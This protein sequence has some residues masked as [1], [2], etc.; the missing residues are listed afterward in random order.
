MDTYYV[1][2]LNDLFV[3]KSLIKSLDHKVV[4]E[5][6]E[7]TT[8]KKAAYKFPNDQVAIEVANKI[9]GRVVLVTETLKVTE[10]YLN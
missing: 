5:R 8:R 7:L 2:E 4:W 9:N 6:I 1:V 3:E 10:E